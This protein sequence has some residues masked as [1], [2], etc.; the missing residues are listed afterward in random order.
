[1]SDPTT[2]ALALLSLLQSHRHWKG[3]ELA[4]RLSVSER[5]VRRD[6]DRL[7]EL[8]YPV[9]ASAGAEGGYRLAVGAHI[10]PLLLGDDDA[11]A[12]VLGLRTAAVTAIEGIEETTVQLMAK[13][14]Q[15]LPDRL[16]RRVDA[17]QSSVEVLRWSPTTQTVPAAA[18]TVLST[19]CREHE[20][21][22]FA[23][24]RRDGEESQRLVRPH[25]LVSAGRR[26]YLV[27]WDVRREDWRTFRVD[28][29][30]DTRA[31]GVR[32]EPLELPA[33]D[34]ATFVAEGIRTM[35]VEHGATV[36]VAATTDELEATSR[37]FGVVPEALG[38][39]R[40][41][42]DLRAETIEW[43]ASMV[44]ILSTSFDLEVTEAP[45]G[46]LAL[47]HTASRRLGRIAPG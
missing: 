47:L 25:Q 12:L 28:R 9:D 44:A 13:L 32:F 46:V 1:M 5:T 39:H 24:R 22:R 38:E 30:S 15:I 41:R 29:M 7:R 42:L 37:W 34:A 26:W 6:V 18:L 40:T 36:V 33:V 11:I 43:L 20:E 17:L 4:A 2:R 21:I 16:R 27:G 23:Y 19:G 3:S 8:G 14:D 35:T 31:A 10:P 45:P